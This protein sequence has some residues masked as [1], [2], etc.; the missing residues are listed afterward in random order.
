[1]STCAHF[2]GTYV[3]KGVLV[4][5]VFGFDYLKMIMLRND[6]IRPWIHI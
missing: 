5:Q 4:L 1:M 2:M 3:A 6:K